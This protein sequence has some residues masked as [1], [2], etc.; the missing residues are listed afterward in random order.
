MFEFRE[1][2]MKSTNR[3]AITGGPK[4][5]EAGGTHF[6]RQE[7]VNKQRTNNAPYLAA[8]TSLHS[9][10]GERQVLHE[11]GK[12]KQQCDQGGVFLIAAR[13]GITAS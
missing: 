4:K 8:A 13:R 11:T 10:G 5:I 3:R 1:H 7:G 12:W 6:S 9:F 2:K